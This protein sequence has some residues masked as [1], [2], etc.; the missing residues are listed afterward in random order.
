MAL[1]VCAST[2]EGGSFALYQGLYP[3]EDVDHDAD[4]TLTGD[5]A[6]GQEPI[7]SRTLKDR[8]RW[9]LLLW[10]SKSSDWIITSGILPTTGH[11]VSLV[12]RA[13]YSESP[14]FM[15]LSKFSPA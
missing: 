1:T 9:P 6:G 11:S 3:R 13:S 8:V 7:K 10:V 2:G 5:Y 15:T 12:Q 14:T 4:R